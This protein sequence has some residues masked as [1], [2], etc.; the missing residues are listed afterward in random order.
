MKTKVRKTY[1]YLIRILIIAATYGFIYKQIFRQRD[2][3]ATYNTFQDLFSSNWFIWMIIVVFLLMLL[4]WGIE[5]LKWC[6]LIRKIERVSWIRSFEAVLSGVAISS[7]TPN[8]VGD[9]FGRVF[10]LERGNRIEGILIT[11]LGSMSQLLITFVLGTSSI[12]LLFIGYHAELLLYFSIPAYLYAYFLW[13][14]GI[15][16]LGLNILVILLFLNISV[17]SFLTA[18]LKGKLLEKLTRYID[19]LSSY[20]IRELIS[21]IFLSLF[22]FVVFSFQMYLL[23]K[24]FSVDLPF[25]HAMIIIAVTFFVMTIIPTITITELGIRG[26]VALFLIGMYFGGPDIAP[27][28]INLGI[29]AASTSLW[30]INLAIP[31]LIGAIFV[32]NL[33]FFRKS[34]Q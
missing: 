12:F 25:F 7:F 33:K 17:F 20:T 10:I 29:I 18:R 8:R 3:S 32:L 15:L 31:A 21:I 27:Q 19:I 6:F 24:I 1:N 4:N 23:L 14:G 28:S 34:K 16:I 11:F 22:R 9:Y 30:I 5:A 2:L 13:G 26:S